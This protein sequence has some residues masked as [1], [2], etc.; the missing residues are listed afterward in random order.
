MPR[1]LQ[2]QID[3][4]N[5]AIMQLSGQATGKLNAG[6]QMMQGQMPDSSLVAQLQQLQQLM[7]KQQKDKAAQKDAEQVTR[8]PLPG[9]FS[10]AQMSSVCHSII[11]SIKCRTC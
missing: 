5:S 6:S 1:L 3:A 4:T 8:G 11:T 7:I 2:D 10:D 9:S